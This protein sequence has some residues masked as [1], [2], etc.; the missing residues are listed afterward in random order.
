MTTTSLLHGGTEPSSR[1]EIAT[2]AVDEVWDASNVGTLDD[3][4]MKCMVERS[5]RVVLAEDSVVLRD[6]MVELLS[7]RGCVVVAAVS[8]AEDLL[9]AAAEH[10]PDVARRGHPDAALAHRR[11]HPCRP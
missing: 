1:P 10:G 5:L 8:C 3:G 2:V 6:G 4:M 11:G 7:A 9:A